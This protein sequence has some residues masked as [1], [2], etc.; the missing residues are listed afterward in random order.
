MNTPTTTLAEHLA[1]LESIGAQP[2]CC[3][4]AWRSLGRGYGH[5]WVRMDTDPGCQEHAKAA[6]R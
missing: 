1:W 2:C 4:Y 5:G 3:R 6:R